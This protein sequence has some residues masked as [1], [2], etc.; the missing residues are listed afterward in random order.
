MDDLNTLRPQLEWSTFS[1]QLV[2][3]DELFSFSVPDDHLIPILEGLHP[4]DHIALY[5][6]NLHS[7]ADFVLRMADITEELSI[8]T[9]CKEVD[10]TK[11]LSEDEIKSLELSVKKEGT[12]KILQDFVAH[13]N[14]LSI[15]ILI[16]RLP[17]G[18]ISTTWLLSNAPKISPR[19]YSIAS[20]SEDH[21][22][23]SI[24]QSTYVFS[25]TK[26]SGLTSRWLRSLKAGDTVKAK[27]CPTIF[28][29]PRN[30][31][32]P[33]IMIATGSGIGE[34]VGSFMS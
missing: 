5:P 31:E 26:K 9:L 18:T 4:G 16:S 7:T 34:I 11:P 22:E 30:R 24:F 29:L 28:R 33:I 23:V 25:E 19:F 27:F 10:L 14:C 17:P 1:N 8:A 15:E 6:N 20:I 13:S 3:S 2:K 12:R 21:R 32:C